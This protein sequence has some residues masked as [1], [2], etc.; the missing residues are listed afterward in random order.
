MIDHLNGAFETVDYREKAHLRIYNND[1]VE[2]YPSHWH[3]ELEIIHICEGSLKVRCQGIDYCLQKGDTLFIC[4]AAIHEIYSAPSGI[5]FY[6][7]ADMSLLSRLQ[8]LSTIFSLISPAALITPSLFPSIFDKI[9]SQIKYIQ[10]ICSTS[11]EEMNES[12]DSSI[13]FIDENNV[14]PFLG[15]IK[16]YSILLNCLFEIGRN[17]PEYSDSRTIT[18]DS[19]SLLRNPRVMQSACNYIDTHFR[20]NI[21]LESVAQQ[22]GFSKFYFERLFKQFTNMTFYQYV[23]KVRLSYAQQLLADRSLSINEVALRSG[24]SSG[25]ALTRSFRQATGLPPSAFRQIKENIE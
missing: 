18:A 14:L 2:N 20:E 17:I 7:Q 15:E 10:E 25:S 21:T 11:D 3:N 16:I 13:P 8:E 22:I 24:F 1:V 12:A 19:S 6:I 4:P 5:R 23:L 9:N